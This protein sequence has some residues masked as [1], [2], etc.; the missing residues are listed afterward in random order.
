[1]VGIGWI[2]GVALAARRIIARAVMGSV[3]GTDRGCQAAL[4]KRKDR[5]SA[6][7]R[8][9]EYR[10][11]Q[12]QSIFRTSRDGFT[13]Q[14]TNCGPTLIYALINMPNPFSP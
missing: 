9:I 3:E 1:L 2:I 13:R 14:P 12:C 7:L 5:E 8:Q 4:Q 10:E 6:T 11:K